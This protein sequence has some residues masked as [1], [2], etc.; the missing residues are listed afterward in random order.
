MIPVRKILDISP[1]LLITSKCLLCWV[2]KF[3][4]GMF[5]KI[6]QYFLF[7]ILNLKEGMFLMML[8]ILIW[9][10]MFLLINTQNNTSNHS[11]T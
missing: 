6:V 5:S 10:V 4:F 2:S 8:L 7:Y 11:F 3:K 9:L 1:L